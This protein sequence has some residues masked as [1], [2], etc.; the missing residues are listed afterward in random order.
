[1]EVVKVPQ[2]ILDQIA[3]LKFKREYVLREFGEIGIATEELKKRKSAA[4]NYRKTV[5]E[6]E[7][8]LIEYLS[9]KYG[10]GTINPDTG[11]FQPLT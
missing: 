8:I 5:L 11:E 6:E 1:M 2:E 7:S 4:V 9:S 3:E 10:N